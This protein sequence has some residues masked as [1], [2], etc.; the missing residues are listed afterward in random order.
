MNEKLR[1]IKAREQ[2]LA[3]ALVQIGN[4]D[5]PGF[6]QASRDLRYLK[7]MDHARATLEERANELE[8]NQ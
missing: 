7:L 3:D 5:V 1:T 2:K 4:A 8:S 6:E